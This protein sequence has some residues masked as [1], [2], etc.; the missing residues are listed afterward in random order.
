MQ[1]HPGKCTT[2]SITRSHNQRPSDYRLHGHTLETVDHAKYLGVTLHQQMNWDTHIT[3]IIGKAS[4]TLGF[5]KRSLKI[6]SPKLK[7]KAYLAFVRPIL[8]YASSIWDPS[9]QVNID[10]IEMVQRRAARYVLNRYSPESSVTEMLETLG[11]PT[12]QH[13]RTNARLSMLTKIKNNQIRV[14]QNRLVATTERNRRCHRGQYERIAC[15]TGYRHASFFPRTI[16][17]WNSLQP[18]ADDSANTLDNSQLSSSE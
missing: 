13:R 12:L 11:W 3:N 14:K 5:L 17:D 10:R 18:G 8:E 1:F 15:R 6:S 7:A 16:R 9:T 4:Q 2:L